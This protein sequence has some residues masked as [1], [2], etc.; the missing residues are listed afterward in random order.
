MKAQNQKIKNNKSFNKNQVG[1]S[2][3]ITNNKNISL[4]LNNKKKKAQ[5]KTKELK[6]K[7]KPKPKRNNPIKLD[8]SNLEL[9]L[10]NYITNTNYISS[11]NHNS[12]YHYI[13]NADIYNN[14]NSVSDFSMRNTNKFKNS[15]INNNDKNFDSVNMLMT[16]N[17]NNE[18]Q[19]NCKRAI[20]RLIINSQNLL[21][22]QNNILLECDLLTKNAA[23]NDYAIKNLI[24]NDKAYNNENILEK[25][26]NNV[27][28]ILTKLKKNDKDFEI[29][30]QL[31]NENES[32]RNKL[33]MANID[34]EE[35]FQIVSNELS[36]LKIVLVNEINHL[37]NIFK[38]F[39]YDNL[40]QE[41]MDINNITSQKIADFF[42]LIIKIVRQM[43]ELIHNKETLISKMTIDQVTNR[44]NFDNINK[45]YEKLNIDNKYSIGYKTYNFSVRNNFHNKPYNISFRN[46]PKNNKNIDIIERTQ[47]SLNITDFQN[48]NKYLD[49]DGLKYSNNKISSESIN[50]NHNNENIKYINENDESERNYQTGNF[51]IK[52]ILNINKNK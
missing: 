23:T 3:T 51:A 4:K 29:N 32:L 40:P 27:L 7:S 19:N 16:N 12:N 8:N 33:E 6:S 50:N 38:E 47:K 52:D 42:Q 2:K 49:E 24:Q 43:K 11:D 28:E 46:M 35:N 14:Y 22:K 41:K 20:D 34:K 21:E 45:S 25:Y 37:L 30:A 36:S 9:N 17:Q 10:N 44:S 15:L 26:N 39:G 5:T 18:N 1:K 48:N 13:P 31:K